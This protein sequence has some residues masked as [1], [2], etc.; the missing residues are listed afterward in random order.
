MNGIPD[1]GAPA[2]TCAALERAGSE[3]GWGH[4]P[5]PLSFAFGD[6]IIRAVVIDDDPWFVLSD[7]CRGIDIGNVGNVA[8][9]L[10]RSGAAIRQTDIRSG[11]Q[12]RLVTI[13]DESGMYEA[14]IRSD[15]PEATRFRRWITSE[16]LPAI[17]KTGSYSR[18][19]AH[20]TAALPSK[21]ELAQWVIEAEERAE[22]AE[23]QVRELAP[24]AAAWN[25]LADAVGDYSVSDAAKVLSRDPNIKTGERRLF[26]YLAAIG[27][28]FRSVTGRWRIYQTQIENG[29]LAEKVG[30][31]YWHE[32]R[33][34]M[35]NSDP[36]VRVTPKGLAELHKRL[37]GTGQLPVA[38]AS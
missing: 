34:E 29:R 30:K 21:K 27:W 35:V 10:N 16:V 26:E 7:I 24:P 9:R 31:P 2:G 1:P 18:Y 33:G 8:E 17:R 22:A 19:P 20:P 12:M 4:G 3:R 11:G 37:G 23:A 13:V 38:A 25:E 5:D 36:I 6:H 32:G 14:V 15:K 28:I